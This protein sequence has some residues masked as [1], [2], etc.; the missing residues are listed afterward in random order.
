[1]GLWIGGTQG[2]TTRRQGARFS[3]RQRARLP[4]GRIQHPRPGDPSVSGGRHVGPGQVTRP[5]SERTPP[6]P[7]SDRRSTAPQ[8]SSTR[9]QARPGRRNIAAGGPRQVV[10]GAGGGHEP[11][12]RSGAARQAGGAEVRLSGRGR[13]RA[14]P[15][16][17]RRHVPGVPA[18]RQLGR[19][20]GLPTARPSGSPASPQPGRLAARPP[21]SP[22]VWQPGLLTAR[23]SGSP[24]SS[25]PDPRA[26]RPFGRGSLGRSG[27]SAPCTPNWMII[28]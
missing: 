7:A 2:A 28:K 14:A 9:S 27:R 20:P 8:T 10:G 21:P 25:Q 23:P 24:A 4:A 12:K 26:A 11:G 15:G 18:L 16:P 17:L 1:M 13:R 5:S 22:A 3:W 19:Q 6:Q